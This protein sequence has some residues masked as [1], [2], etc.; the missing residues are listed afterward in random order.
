MLNCLA[1]SERDVSNLTQGFH[2]T[3]LGDKNVFALMVT[4]LKYGENTYRNK[5]NNNSKLIVT[6]LITDMDLIS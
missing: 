4:P 2:L 3:I 6:P 1:Q 5:N